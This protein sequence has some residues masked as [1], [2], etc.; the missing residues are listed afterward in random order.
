MLPKF[1]HINRRIGAKTSL[2][3]YEKNVE[4]NVDD[5]IRVFDSSTINRPTD[6]PSRI[7]TMFDHANLIISAWDANKLVGVCRA[8]TDFIY[9]C[10]LSD[11]AVD[12][13]YQRQGIGT[14]MIENIR[15]EI[16]EKAS[17]VL[18]SAPGAMEYYPKVGF[19]KIGN[20]YRIQRK[21]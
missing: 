17:I 9:C 5:I 16:G 6:D 21:F 4:L 19:E 8:L 14:A 10:Y 11:L 20:G 1:P 12:F 13:E 15:H 18:L 3:K 2:I 7:K